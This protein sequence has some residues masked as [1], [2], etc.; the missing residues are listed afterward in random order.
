MPTTEAFS[1]NESLTCLA[2]SLADISLK[3]GELWHD[4]QELKGELSLRED[5]ESRL[6]HL[7]RMMHAALLGEGDDNEPSPF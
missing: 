3:L 2:H 1:M 5:L 6:W 4:L 7:E